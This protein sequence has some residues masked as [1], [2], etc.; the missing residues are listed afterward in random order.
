M[1][2]IAKVNRDYYDGLY[3]QGNPLMHLIRAHISF[4]QRS[5]SRSNY[6]VIGPVIAQMIKEQEKVKVLDYGSGWGAFLLNLPRDPII[7]SYCFDISDHAIEGLKRAMNI[8]GRTVEEV[9]IDDKGN[10]TPNNF[11]LIVCSHVLEHVESDQNLLSQLVQALR[12]GG[13]LLVNVPINEVW[14]DPKHVRTYDLSRLK[15]VLRNAELRIS[16][17]LKSDKWSGYIL[18]RETRTTKPLVKI[19]LRGFRALLAIMPYEGVCW[20]E[21][22]LPEEPYHQLI[23]L[24]V[25]PNG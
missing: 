23:M 12:P 13:Y 25:K 17:Q 7:D 11:D 5:K 9:S 22:F 2:D 6:T 8:L 21:K 24:G 15:N 16:D 1:N 4:D 19:A 20:S 3:R 10:I 14:D 18:R